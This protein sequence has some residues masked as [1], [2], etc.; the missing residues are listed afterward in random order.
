MMWSFLIIAVY[1][2]TARPRQAC[3]VGV[4]F[5]EKF[6]FKAGSPLAQFKLCIRMSEIIRRKIHGRIKTYCY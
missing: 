5:D 4:D 2:K 6:K 1:K 3:L